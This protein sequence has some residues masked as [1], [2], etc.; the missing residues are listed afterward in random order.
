V[1][2]PTA[3]GHPRSSSIL[4]TP[5]WRPGGRGLLPVRARRRLAEHDPAGL[6]DPLP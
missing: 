6:G 5:R 4:M 3:T 2:Y 1:R